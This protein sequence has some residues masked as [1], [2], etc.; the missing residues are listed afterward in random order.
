MHPPRTPMAN[1]QASAEGYSRGENQGNL[2]RYR[3]KF[4]S[5]QFVC[6]QRCGAI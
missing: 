2:G 5:R 3:E 4:L 6:H 1:G